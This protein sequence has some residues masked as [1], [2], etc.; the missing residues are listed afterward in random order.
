MRMT[1]FIYNFFLIVVLLFA[2]SEITKAQLLNNCNVVA[3]LSPAV[4]SILSPGTALTLQNASTNAT[5]FYFI[6][7]GFN[8]YTFPA[9]QPYTVGFEVGI[10]SVQIVATNGICSDTSRKFNFLRTGVLPPNPEKVTKNYGFNSGGTLIGGALTLLNGDNLIFGGTNPDQISAGTIFRT[11]PDGCLLWATKIPNI[12]PIEYDQIYGATELPNGQILILS[13][14]Q[15]SEK[16]ISKL[17]SSGTL[18]WSKGLKDASNDFQNTRIIEK[19][20]DNGFVTFSRKWQDNGFVIT[21]FTSSAQILWQKFFKYNLFDYYYFDRVAIMGNSLYLAANISHFTNGG[22]GA[23]YKSIISKIN[24]INGESLWV[25]DYS[26]GSVNPVFGDIIKLDSTLLINFTGPTGNIQKTPIGGLMQIDTAGN[27]LKATLVTEDYFPNPTF[28]PFGA[29][30]KRLIE[31]GK[32]Y[33]LLSSG[34]YQIFGLQGNGA[35]SKVIRFDSA[36]QLKWAYQTGGVSAP[37]YH[38]LTPDSAKGCKVF[39]VNYTKDL[40][41]YK[42]SNRFQVDRIDTSGYT[43]NPDCFFSSQ[44]AEIQNVSVSAAMI[45]WSIDSVCTN[46]VEDF[47][48]PSQSAFP[49]IRYVCPD[50]IDSCSLFA[51]SGQTKVCNLS[52]IYTYKCHKN[53]ACNQPTTW[54]VS[55]NVQIISLTDSLLKVKFLNFGRHVIYGKKLIGCFKAEDSVVVNALSSSPPLNLGDDMGICV[56][57]IKILHAGNKYLNYQW[58][59]GSTDSTL[60]LSQP[61]LYWVKVTDSC[62]NILRDTINVFISPAPII[63][64]GN[65]RTICAKDTVH[66]TASAGFL[67]YQWSPN[68]QTN[69]TLGQ[70]IIVNPLIDTVYFVRAEATSGCF[71]FDTIKIKVNNSPAINLGSDKSICAGDSIILDAGSGFSFYNW[72]NSMSTQIVVLKSQGIYSIEAITQLGCKSYDTFRIVNVHALPNLNLDKNPDLCI[73]TNKTLDAGPGLVSYNWNTGETTQKIIINSI[74]TYK[75]LVK[76]INGCNGSDSTKI[77][78][79]KPRPSLF[80]ANDILLCSHESAILK[81]NFTFSKYLWND[82]SR[83]NSIIVSPPAIYWLEVTDQYGCI[84]RDSI[85]VSLKNDCITGVNVPNAFTPNGDQK[86]DLFK[87]LVSENLTKYDFRIYNRFG[88]LIFQSNNVS[89][90]WNGKVNQILQE[91]GAYIWTLTYQIQ[92]QATK[93]QEGSFLLIR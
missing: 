93:K 58:Q 39:G 68:Y 70:T 10:T 37:R 91:N 73:G 31:S 15:Q 23:N 34:G 49:D 81:P 71:G 69:S 33:Y 47:I 11:S 17:T 1:G 35:N 28:G 87:P 7:N 59:D 24:L 79:I 64:I 5:S 72:S 45:Q 76:D 54:E 61:G 9:N 32:N 2:S 74:G 27:V 53:K 50:Y 48:L 57:N 55:S 92:G 89:E 51:M 62:Q 13:R 60:A 36:F 52:Q 30:N 80:L 78:T 40:Q 88:N 16:Y 90:G 75:V 44:P 66:L 6:V 56:G 86:N 29:S 26:I 41:T 25:K 19:L 84:G 14:F 46:T 65:D 3:A 8:W 43:T 85:L 77:L 38:F 63:S 42:L 82:G 83:N 18:V 67:N 4:D 20:P 12:Y 22:T 21:R